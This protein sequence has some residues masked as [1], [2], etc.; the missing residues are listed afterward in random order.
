MTDQH[1]KVTVAPGRQGGFSMFELVVTI[2]MASILASVIVS[3]FQDLPAEAE[4]ANFIAVVGQLKAGVNLRMMS[5]I[6]GGSWSELEELN[7]SN[8]M[9]LLLQRPINY[10]GEFDHVGDSFPTRVW[11]FDSARGELV[12]RAGSAENLYTENADN[13]AL[14][15][16]R[17]SINNTYVGGS[18]QGLELAPVVPYRWSRLPVEEQFTP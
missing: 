2:L 10:L 13:A 7:A 8:P 6:A 11:Y 18:W 15:S 1:K 12:Y 5:A 9:K 4:R 3:R 17:F 14:K 16:I